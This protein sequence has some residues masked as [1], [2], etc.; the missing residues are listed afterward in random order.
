MAQVTD[1]V[2]GMAIDM[3]DVEGESSWKETTYHFCSTACKATFDVDPDGYASGEKGV[4]LG[5][6]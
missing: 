2:C 4:P 3:D 5:E 1:V 6:K